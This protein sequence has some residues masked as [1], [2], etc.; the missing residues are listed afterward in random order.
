MK[1]IVMIHLESEDERL[2]TYW[3]AIQDRANREWSALSAKQDASEVDEFFYHRLMYAY[4]QL[5]SMADTHIEEILSGRVQWHR[6]EAERQQARKR[7]LSQAKPGDILHH[8]REGDF[9]LRR[10]NKD[11]FRVEPRGGGSQRTLPQEDFRDATHAPE[12]KPPA[13][14]IAHPL[15]DS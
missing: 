8:R 6:H 5:R 11:T 15:F 7:R 14:V 3:Q 2:L 4:Y 12:I 10:R 9:I 13:Q 1:G